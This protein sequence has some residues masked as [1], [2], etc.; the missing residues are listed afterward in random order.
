[1]HRNKFIIGKNGSKIK[2]IGIRARQDIEYK[3]KKKIFLELNVSLR[4][5]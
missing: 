1:M 4:K 2:Q 5:K 3:L